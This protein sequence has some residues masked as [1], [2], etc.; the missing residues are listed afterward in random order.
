MFMKYIYY[1]ELIVR[2]TQTHFLV[3]NGKEMDRAMFDLL[4]LHWIS[5]M[6]ECGSYYSFNT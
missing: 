4:I 6:K 2:Y 5:E 1:N 3:N